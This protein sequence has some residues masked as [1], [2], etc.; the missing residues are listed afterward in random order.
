[1]AN[2]VLTVIQCP[3][4]SRVTLEQG[5]LGRVAVLPLRGAEGDHGCLR[6]ATPSDVGTYSR[7]KAGCQSGTWS[8]PEPLP[9]LVCKAALLPAMQALRAR[10]AV[11]AGAGWPDSV[12][13]RVSDFAAGA[14]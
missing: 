11:S 6:A 13:T 14:R 7:L 1:M 5:D 4:G 12:T 3:N 10:A 8:R 2:W 9:R